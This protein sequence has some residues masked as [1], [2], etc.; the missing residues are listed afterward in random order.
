MTIRTDV[1]TFGNDKGVFSRASAMTAED[2]TALTG[3]GAQTETASTAQTETAAVADAPSGNG[4]DGFASSAN[5]DTMVALVNRT[6]VRV[7]EHRL[8]LDGEVVR[9]AEHR[10]IL[11]AAVVRVGELDTK[12]A[13][14]VTRVK[15]IE[16][17]LEALGVVATN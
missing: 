6:K 4:T 14:L 16:N 2:A 5:H 7:A 9:V 3:A 10:T 8:I 11:D 17:I 12:Q 15:E 13:L 1:N